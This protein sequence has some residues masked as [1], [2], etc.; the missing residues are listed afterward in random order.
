MRLLGAGPAPLWSA[1][2]GAEI[3]IALEAGS[4]RWI[5]RIFKWLCLALLVYIGVPFVTHVDWASVLRGVLGTQFRLEPAYPALAVAVLGTTVSPYMF[6]TPSELLVFS[7]IVNGIAAGPF[8]VIVVL[9]ARDG[10]I[11]GEYRNRWLSQ[12]LGWTTA[13]VMYAAGGFGAW[14][15]LFGGGR[16]ER[17]RG[18]AV[19]AR[20][21]TIGG[22]TERVDAENVKLQDVDAALIAV[23]VMM[24]V[25]ARSV[26]EVEDIVTSPQ[27][28]VLVTIATRGPQNLGEIATELGV[29]A[30][31]ATRTSEKL[32][33]A[34]LISRTEDPVDRRFVRLTLTGQGAALVD[35]VIGHRRKAL[36]NVLAAMKPE[37]RARA[38]DG[39]RAF[40]RAAGEQHADDGRFTLVRPGLTGDAQA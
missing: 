38:T 26:A 23:D 1:I 16:W 8:V 39:F 2:A 28:R 40:A 15:T 18:C 20:A 6:V 35:Q 5:G 22:T 32:V 36:A 33:H 29:H 7:A 31:N 12:T 11:M 30:S 13:I 37:D 17:P 14:Y 34:G 3:A 27:L 25:A 21:Q 9:I 4:F 19:L 24:G 10:R